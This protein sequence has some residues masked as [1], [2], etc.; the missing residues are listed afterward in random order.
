MAKMKNLYGVIAYDFCF[1]DN[2]DLECPINEVKIVTNAENV[3][4]SA[5]L[6]QNYTIEWVRGRNV[7]L[8]PLIGLYLTD[9]PCSGAWDLNPS[10]SHKDADVNVP[11]KCTE[12]NP[13]FERVKGWNISRSALYL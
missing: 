4:N 5:L 9:E 2:R 12:V 1:K 7:S 6:S 3:T 10:F 8:D 13:L 11:R